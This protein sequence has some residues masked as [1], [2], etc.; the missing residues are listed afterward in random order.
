MLAPIHGP[1]YPLKRL[2]IARYFLVILFDG[3][4]YGQNREENWTPGQNRRLEGVGDVASLANPTPHPQ[5]LRA[6]SFRSL[7]AFVCVNR[8]AVSSTIIVQNQGIFLV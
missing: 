6:R 4:T 1:D 8:D 7:F 2:F 5:V 3:R